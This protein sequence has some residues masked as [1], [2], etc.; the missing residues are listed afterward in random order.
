M[1]RPRGLRQT[2]RF[3]LHFRSSGLYLNNWTAL[4]LAAPSLGPQAAVVQPQ[5]PG[6]GTILQATKT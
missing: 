3:D 6:L 2:W 1:A 5:L 4:A